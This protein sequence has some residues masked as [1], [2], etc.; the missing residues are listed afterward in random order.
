MLILPG[1]LE[2]HCVQEL[3]LTYLSGHGEL[4]VALHERRQKLDHLVVLT[5]IELQRKTQIAN[6]RQLWTGVQDMAKIR[7]RPIKPSVC[8]TSAAGLSSSLFFCDPATTE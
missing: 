5:P 3:R 2:A 1:A 7:F 6:F 8:L 4:L